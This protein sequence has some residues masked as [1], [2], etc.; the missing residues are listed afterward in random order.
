MCLQ[1]QY[2]AGKSSIIKMLTGQ[3]DIDIGAGITT[4][5]THMYD[6]KG[7]CIIDTPGID[8]TLRPDHDEISYDAIANADMLVFVITNELFDSYIGQHFRKLAIE[9]DKAGEM[10]LVVNKMERGDN[11]NTPDK[12]K[13]IKDDLQKVTSPYTPDDLHVCFVDAKSYLESINEEDKEIKQALESRSGCKVFEETLN[14]FVKEREIPARLTTA[15]YKLDEILQHSIAKLQPS[16]GDADIDALKEQYLQERDILLD[17]RRRAE[18]GVERIYTN[19]VAKIINEGIE[20]ANIITYEVQ[21]DEVNHLLEKAISKVESIENN[22]EQEVENELSSIVKN[23]ERLFEELSKSEFSQKL[24]L[25]IENRKDGIS[26]RILNPDLL[27]QGGR[28]IVNNALKEGATFSLNSISSFSQSP[29]HN[30][31]KNIGRF[32]G[33]KFKPWEA[34]KVTKVIGIAG[35]ALA[36]FGIV[37]SV[38]SQV[39]ED[40]EMKKIEN[41]MRSNREKIRYNFNDEAHKFEKSFNNSFRAFISEQFDAPIKEIDSKVDEIRKLCDN[42]S[43]NCKLLESLLEENRSLIKEIHNSLSQI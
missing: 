36:L 4:Q 29:I 18:Q 40:K 25:R 11:G 9:R 27:N 15:L 24:K 7:V 16:S 10:V 2:S 12:Q 26:S 30:A 6:W 31:V 34:V 21:E 19:T 42:K 1:G 33:H 17:T 3:T 35:A 32:F 38:Y 39:K 22:C 13:T 28:F 23:C 14:N 5:Q 41:E 8:T 37:F 20:V 43:K